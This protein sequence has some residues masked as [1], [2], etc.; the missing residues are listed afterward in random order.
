MSTPES[1]LESRDYD[2]F[3][4]GSSE[5]SASLD[6][7]ITVEETKVVEQRPNKRKDSGI[8]S[9][10]SNAVE[11]E[12]DRW[13]SRCDTKELDSS[14]A[15]S[16]AMSETALSVNDFIEEESTEAEM[17][18]TEVMRD[19]KEWLLSEDG[20]AKKVMTANSYFRYTKRFLEAHVENP[21]HLFNFS[22]AP[23]DENGI[24]E[25]DFA[26]VT[27][28]AVSDFLDSCK[29]PAVANVALHGIAR[30]VEFIEERLNAWRGTPDLED[31]L[32][33]RN[34]QRK[35]RIFTRNIVGL[36]KKWFNESQEHMHNNSVMRKEMG[37][38]KYNCSL[39]LALVEQ[40]A[41]LEF[42][43]FWLKRLAAL[44]R[45]RLEAVNRGQGQPGNVGLEMGMRECVEV[46]DFLMLELLLF[47]G[48]SRTDSIQ[49]FTVDEFNSKVT[50]KTNSGQTVFVVSVRNHKTGKSGKSVKWP[51][52][53]L[54]LC[55]GLSFFINNVRPRFV[56]GGA[57]KVNFVFLTQKGERINN[58]Q[59]VSEMFMDKSEYLGVDPIT[60]IMIRTAVA[61][62]GSTHTNTDIK[63][64]IAEA[65][66]HSNA[67]H[68]KFY[69]QGNER[70]KIF[71][72]ETFRNE[73][74]AATQQQQQQPD[75]TLDDL[76][77]AA[78]TEMRAREVRRL[79]DNLRHERL[80][81]QHFNPRNS[82]TEEH[83]R[84]ILKAFPRETLNDFSIS[85]KEVFDVLKTDDDLRRVCRE[86]NEMY[87]FRSDEEFVRMA[88]K[89]YQSAHG[90]MYR[91][92]QRVLRIKTRRERRAK[93]W[94]VIKNAEGNYID[95]D[96]TVKT[97]E[98]K[99][100]GNDWVL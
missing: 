81:H 61:T 27:E 100:V 96:G 76:F 23:A 21:L 35:Y 32:R 36:K 78:Q 13:I 93:G 63:R 87:G 82:L 83:R 24:A 79:K 74:G 90:N 33:K 72:T 12:V 17:A 11:D 44:E 41:K 46:R 29:T 54:K 84:I 99:I 42:R 28:E 71:I 91:Y 47:T 69:N 16:T 2:E 1:T 34:L 8:C 25:A 6:E 67:T 95:P 64:N 5:S 51:I 37:S 57:K 80:E 53:S 10:D 15:E 77:V 14:T 70:A 89:A 73:L 66:N 3:I 94:S 39:V 9:L 62:W 20:A 92:E 26:E 22:S 68:D 4:A 85:S 48:G 59:K 56:D 31:K 19:Y 43:H 55:K 45:K 49:N 50:E 30:F 65:L 86:V 75:V 40:Y 97:P 58:F 18:F 98:G 88:K 52:S 7:F 60:P 38:V